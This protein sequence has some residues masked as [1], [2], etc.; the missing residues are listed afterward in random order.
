VTN[1]P[2]PGAFVYPATTRDLMEVYAGDGSSTIEVG[3]V[4]PTRAIRASLK[5]DALLGKHFAL[6]G[7]TGTGKSTTLA[8]ILHRICQSAPQGHVL[9]I[10]PHGE[11][12]AAFKEEGMI[13]DVSNLQLPYWLMNFEE[14]CEILLSSRGI[15]GRWMPRFWADACCRRARRT[16]WPRI[17]G[18]SRWIRRSPICSPIWA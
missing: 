18:G 14:H 6:L 17:W 8:L 2:L 9:M 13:L 4:F 16:G 7:S 10:D 12:A 1:Y 3:T 5:I 15:C 11:Y